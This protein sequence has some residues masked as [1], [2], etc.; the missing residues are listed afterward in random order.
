[1]ECDFIDNS[2]SSECHIEGN[3]FKSKNIGEHNE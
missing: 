3:K 2:L 1:M